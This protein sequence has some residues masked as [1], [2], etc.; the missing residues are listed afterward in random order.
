MQINVKKSQYYNQMFCISTSCQHKAVEHGHMTFGG[1]LCD[2]HQ[3]LRSPSFGSCV[4]CGGASA[5]D[6]FGLLVAFLSVPWWQ[7]GL[8]VQPLW[9]TSEHCIAVMN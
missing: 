9:F 4:L 2:C 5:E 1:V 8:Q 7:G 3:D 6:N